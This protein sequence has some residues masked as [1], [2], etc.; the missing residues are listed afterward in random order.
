MAF[1]GTT[2]ALCY[3]IILYSTVAK[4]VRDRGGLLWPYKTFD[5][6]YN[7][8]KILPMLIEMDK[9][10]PIDSDSRVLH[11]YNYANSL[12]QQPDSWVLICCSVALLCSQKKIGRKLLK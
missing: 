8:G 3:G 12:L 4:Y 1:I 5:D 6:D 2:A 9:N 7:D 10:T 11:I